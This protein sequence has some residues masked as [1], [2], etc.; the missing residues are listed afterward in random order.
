MHAADVPGSHVVLRQPG[1]VCGSN[2]FVI[3]LQIQAPVYV[4]CHACQPRGSNQGEQAPPDVIKAAA[5]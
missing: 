4:H 1:S 2:C 5:G 3:V